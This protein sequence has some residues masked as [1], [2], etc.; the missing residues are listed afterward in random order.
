VRFRYVAVPVALLLV[1]SPAHADETLE[2][3]PYAAWRRPL[4]PPFF[5]GHPAIRRSIAGAALEWTD[6]PL[7]ERNGWV[8]RFGGAVEHQ[9]DCPTSASCLFPSGGG[10]RVVDLT[11]YSTTL[12]ENH[13][14]WG[15]HA[16]AGWFWRVVQLEGGLLAYT[17]TIAGSPPQPRDVKLLPDAV[18]RIGTRTSFGAIGFGTFTSAAVMTPMTYL[19]GQFVFA[20]RWTATFTLAAHAPPIAS[21]EVD[22]YMHVR[23]D[24]LLRYRIIRAARVGIGLGLTHEDPDAPRTRLGGEVRFVFEWIRPD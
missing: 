18:A 16:R 1:A 17:T 6:A 14:E 11:E 2:I 3:A 12:P 23:H 7:P 24:L 19:Q 8:L 22:P 13:V 15:A 20:R 4:S 9:A 10:G 21:Y 5:P